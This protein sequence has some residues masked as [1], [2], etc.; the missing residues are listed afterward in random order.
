MLLEQAENI[1][2]KI[3]VILNEK[4]RE[5]LKEIEVFVAPSSSQELAGFIKMWRNSTY[6]IALTTYGHVDMNVYLC[7]RGYAANQYEFETIDAFS[8]RT[9]VDFT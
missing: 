7:D 5:G 8:R 3:E 9:G 2:Q 1:R 6:V 4:T